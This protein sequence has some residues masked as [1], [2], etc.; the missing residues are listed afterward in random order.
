M[1]IIEMGISF[2]NEG[3]KYDDAS[4]IPQAI[5]CYKKGLETLLQGIKFEKEEIK[6][7]IFMGKA[8]EVMTRLTYLKGTQEDKMEVV[9]GPGSDGP[10]AS[11][12]NAKSGAKSAANK[13]R[14][15]LNSQIE[16]A[17]VRTK[18]NI[19][20]SDVAGLENAKELLKEAVILPMKFP[21]LFKGKREPW[22]GI[23]LYGVPGTGKSFIAQ[24][25]A[26]ECDATFF[27]ISS[28]DLVSKYQG[29]SERLVKALFELARKEATESGGQ[30]V[31]FIDEVDALCG[32][33]GGEGESES[34]RRIKTEFL[35]QM[36]GVS[37]SIAD[38]ASG[39][40]RI[41]VLGATN[42]PEAL[43]SAIRRR[44]EKRIEITLPEKDARAGILKLSI[45]TTPNALTPEDFDRMADETNGFSGAD[46]NILVRDCLMEPVRELQRASHFRRNRDGKYERCTPDA[47]GAQEMNLMQIPGEQLAVPL[48]TLEHLEHA[49]ANVKPSVSQDDIRRIDEFTK[50][51]G[52]E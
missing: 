47:Q 9:D 3:K 36:N 8:R 21:G 11:S 43:D 5:S 50:K 34:S 17:I 37:A 48:V 1:N 49:R 33:R 31:I 19:K 13:E 42:Y 52:S 20:W 14:D 35:V 28:S 10:R 24:A 27:S 29:E 45:S 7:N 40:G 16:Q 23:L 22:K 30:A 25:V 4:D 12:K 15:A 2:I 46:L 32:A 26:S 41:L 39:A 6:R 18:P 51:F 44:F 38:S